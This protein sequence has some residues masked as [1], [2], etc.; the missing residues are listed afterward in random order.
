MSAAF[1]SMQGLTLQILSGNFSP[2]RHRMTKSGRH[3][4]ARTAEASQ[5]L[6]PNLFAT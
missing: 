1:I 4:A 2:S 6:C 5:E 3:E